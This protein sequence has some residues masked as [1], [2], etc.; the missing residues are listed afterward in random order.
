MA[1]QTILHGSSQ[2]DSI[3]NELNIK[4]IFL[5]HSN[6]YNNL[7][8][9]KEIGGIGAKIAYYGNVKPNPKYEDICEAV[10]M[11]NAERCDAIVA[12]GGGSVIDTAKCVKLF[13]RLDARLNFLEQ[14][15]VESEAPILAVPT[16]AGTGSEST[17]FAVIYHNGQKQ[18]ISHESAMPDYAILMPGLLKTLPPYQK[19]CTFLDA[20]C[21]G[22]ESWW[23]INSTEESRGYSRQAV[24]TLCQA[25]DAYL[26]GDEASME[27]AMYGA[28]YAGRAINIAQTTAPHAMSY[29]LTSLFGLPH[30][31]AVAICLPEVWRYMAENTDN[32]ADRRGRRHVGKV[33]ESIAKAIGRA[34]VYQAIEGLSNMLRQIGIL[35][36]DGVTSEDLMNLA[37]SVNSVRLKNSPVHI[38]EGAAWALY[39]N[40]LQGKK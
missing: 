14:N 11:F 1:K 27:F 12:I 38:D 4:K 8:I 10:S 29:K 28:N 25:M 32:C 22:I 37:E 17:R 5:I 7:S 20:L 40:V 19:K 15:I 9:K 3:I 31:H 26:S 13:C 24:E 21:Q 2:I 18:S 23:S 36:P 35:P 33:F 6:S 16:T 39:N 34:T 30:G